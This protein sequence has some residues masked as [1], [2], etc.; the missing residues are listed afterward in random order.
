MLKLFMVTEVCASPEQ[1]AEEVL[2]F[3]GGR[4]R[5]YKR[6]ATIVTKALSSRS[7]EAFTRLES[8]LKMEKGTLAKINLGQ[9]KVDMHTFEELATF[10]E[11]LPYG[12]VFQSK[13][14]L[15]NEGAQEWHRKLYQIGVRDLPDYGMR[16]ECVSPDYVRENM[17]GLAISALKSSEHSEDR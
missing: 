14:I 2:N 11:D 10:L 16:T 12:A 6:M 8:L 5:L 7:P 13:M 9:R 4:E 17:M 1:V 15:S 3:F